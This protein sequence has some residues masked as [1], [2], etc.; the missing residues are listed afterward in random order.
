MM[1]RSERWARRLR[2]V[3]GLQAAFTAR[4]CCGRNPKASDAALALER[5]DTAGSACGCA[6]TAALASLPTNQGAI[7][8]D[9]MVANFGSTFFW[10]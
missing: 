7:L 6:G 2:F 9:L 4:S 1:H 8:E 3:F 10:S 5:L